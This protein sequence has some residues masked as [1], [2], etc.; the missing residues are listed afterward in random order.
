M[1]GLDE[2]FQTDVQDTPGK[3]Q[4]TGCGTKFFNRDKVF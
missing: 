2:N 1:C 3:S 4:C